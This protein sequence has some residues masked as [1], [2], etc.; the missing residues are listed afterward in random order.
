MT[1]HQKGIM[2]GAGAVLFWSTSAAAT[3]L[4]TQWMGPWQFMAIACLTGGLAQV[5]FYRRQKYAWGRIFR[6]PPR[7]WLPIGPCLVLY[8]IAITLALVLA[9]NP[10]QKIGVSLVNYLWPTLTVVFAVLLVPGAK[11]HPRLAGAVALALAGLV[12]ANWH[13]IRGVLTNTSSVPLFP[14]LLALTAATSWGL[15][16]ATLSR[17]RSVATI[18]P[19]APLGFILTGLIAAGVCTARGGWQP[20]GWPAIAVVL[21]AGLGPQGSG[22]L[23]WEL[24]LH[25]APASEL[26]LLG[27]AAPVLSTLWLVGLFHAG[28]S[29]K[30]NVHVGLLLIAAILIGSAVLIGRSNGSKDRPLIFTN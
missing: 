7:L 22:Y 15:Y 10:T 2:F 29:G 9:V 19:T 28:T 17:W 1:I 21:Y 30:S 24:A 12:L 4:A 18:H 6:P 13:D 27:S 11:M 16:S 23:F 14:Y 25:R 20:L 8:L 5:V 26:G 3:I